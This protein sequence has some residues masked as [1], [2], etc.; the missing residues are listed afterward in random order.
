MDV[1]KIINICKLLTR[2]YSDDAEGLINFIR[3]SE[4]PI[5]DAVNVWQEVMEVTYYSDDEAE[6]FFDSI[7][8]YSIR[9]SD[10]YWLR[11]EDIG[12][13][14]VNINWR[15]AE[16]CSIDPYSPLLDICAEMFKA[17]GWVTEDYYNWYIDEDVMERADMD[18]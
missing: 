2:Q 3:K 14:T 15:D 12:R 17:L 18:A 10:F 4:L 8:K 6:T 5:D 7:D 13:P 16:V 11:A 9:N 1:N